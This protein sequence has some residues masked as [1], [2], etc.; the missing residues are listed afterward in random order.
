MRFFFCLLCI[1]LL[2]RCVHFVTGVRIAYECVNDSR[3]AEAN[4]KL[5]SCISRLSRGMR[6]QGGKS[7]MRVKECKRILP[8]QTKYELHKKKARKAGR[9][10]T[11]TQRGATDATGGR[12]GMGNMRATS[13]LPI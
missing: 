5:T 10:M 8:S 13:A 3:C 2:L 1:S 11:T 7:F 9:T 6:M 12:L 4:R